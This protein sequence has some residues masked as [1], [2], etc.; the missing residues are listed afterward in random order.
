[1][2]RIGCAGI[3][4]VIAVLAFFG[5]HMEYGTEHDVTFTISKMDDQASGSTHKYLVFTTGGQVYEDTDAWLH[6][7]TD[8]SQV[9]AEMAPGQTWQCP[10]YGFRSFWSSGYPDILDGCKMMAAP[11][12]PDS[13]RG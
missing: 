8:S 3:A 1:V 6:G 13:A 4:L 9:W 12:T 5:W 2:G 10:V 7:K 11:F